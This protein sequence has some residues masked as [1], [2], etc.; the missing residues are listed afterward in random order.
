MVSR[1]RAG[2]RAHGELESAVL[3]VLWD[4]DQPLNVS[5]VRERL[6]ARGVGDEN[7][8]AYTTV[9]TVLSRLQEKGTLTRQREGRSYRYA[10]VADQSGLLARQV[11]AIIAAA[12]DREAVLTRFV[13]DLTA[14]DEHLLRSLLNPDTET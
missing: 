1:G 12:N 7:D 9:L 8:F 11:N 5:S 4:A 2:R 13:S 10:P 6:I 14:A 3:E